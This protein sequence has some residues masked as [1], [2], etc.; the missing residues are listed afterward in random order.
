MATVGAPKYGIEVTYHNSVT[1][2]M[3]FATEK[4]RDKKHSRLQKDKNVR[5]AKRITR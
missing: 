4:A 1:T 5:R 2:R 3:W